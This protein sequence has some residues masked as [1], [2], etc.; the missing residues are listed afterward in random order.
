M[1]NLNNN[2]DDDD[3]DDDDSNNLCFCF[4]QSDFYF[5][6]KIAR[7]LIMLLFFQ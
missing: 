1:L 3:D 7:H 4:L 6:Y 5:C 2:D